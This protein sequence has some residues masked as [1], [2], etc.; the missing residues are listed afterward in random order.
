MKYRIQTLRQRKNDHSKF[1]V[2]AAYDASFTAAINQAEIEVILV[3]DS[4]GMVVQGQSS[5]VPVTIEQMVY[6]TEAVA[7]GNAC[8]ASQAL[9]IADMP[10]MS[11][12]NSEDALANAAKLMRAGANMVKLEGGA[13][14]ADTTAKLVE[15]GI[16]VCAHIG[17][18]PQSVNKLGGYKVQGR[19]DDQQ[20]QLLNDA[21]ALDK[22]GS[23]FIVLECIPKSLSAEITQHT[24]FST[25]GIGAGCDTDAQ[26]LVCYDML[27][28]SSSPAKFVKNFLAESG[29]SQTPSIVNAFIAYK[30]AV[31]NSSYPAPEHEYQ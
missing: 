8:G 11:Y 2:V 21:K 6:H 1:S 9:V 20:Q 25:I 31:E 18:T 5:T 27:G 19:S 30:Q 12:A 4:L 14:L 7:R 29:S 3:G 22:A 13:W 23:D 24:D 15:C 10:F 17:L 28:L 26:V 16:P